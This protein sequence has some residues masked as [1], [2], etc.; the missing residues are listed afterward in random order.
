M[1]IFDKPFFVRNYENFHAFSSSKFR[2]WTICAKSWETSQFCIIKDVSFKI[3]TAWGLNTGFDV[4]FS[5]SRF[6]TNWKFESPKAENRHEGPQKRSSR[7]R[8]G[9]YFNRYRLETYPQAKT[10]KTGHAIFF[11]FFRRVQ[12]T[13]MT[14]RRVENTHV[15]FWTFS[16]VSIKIVDF[17]I[18]A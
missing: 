17:K 11:S 13:S 10:S 4:I 14:Q 3:P 7:F 2:W 1:T 12:A 15:H 5:K 8:K 18:F 6:F 16:P 9:T